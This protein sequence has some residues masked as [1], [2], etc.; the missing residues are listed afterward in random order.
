MVPQISGGPDLDGS[1]S[2]WQSGGS[3]ALDRTGDW[4][5]LLPRWGES[6]LQVWPQVW[7]ERRVE[8][9]E[10]P[11]CLGDAHDSSPGL[12]VCPPP[13]THSQPHV[14]CRW[15]VCRNRTYTIDMD[16]LP[17]ELRDAFPSLALLGPQ[18]HGELLVGQ[19]LSTVLAHKVP[20]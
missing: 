9:E 16:G 14:E 7:W 17:A 11:V 2:R 6:E 18:F 20:G 5:W 3:T 13:P 1:W 4:G 19:P 12:W 8:T 10:S 15:Q